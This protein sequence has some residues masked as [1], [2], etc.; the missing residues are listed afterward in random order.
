MVDKNTKDINNLKDCH[1]RENDFKIVQSGFGYRV[2]EN[3]KFIHKEIQ[4]DTNTI[5]DVTFSELAKYVIDDTPIE[6]D[7][8]VKVKYYKG[9]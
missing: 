3:G 4:T 8:T 9:E 1:D 7:K 5:S 6:R 2:E